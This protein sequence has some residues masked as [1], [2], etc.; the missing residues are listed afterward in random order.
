MTGSRVNEKL[1]VRATDDDNVKLTEKKVN[2]TD[3]LCDMPW[4]ET[5]ISA[6]LM[7][8]CKWGETE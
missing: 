6:Y 4:T 2:W 5:G 7:H 3:D 1:C 8:R